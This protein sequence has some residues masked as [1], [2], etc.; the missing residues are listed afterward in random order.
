VVRKKGYWRAIQFDA[1]TPPS[2]QH[3][4]EKI[5]ALTYRLRRWSELRSHVRKG[6]DPISVGDFTA[7]L[8]LWEEI[9]KTWPDQREGY[10]GVI[11]CARETG[12]FRRATTVSAEARQRFP[13]DPYIA[14]ES[15]DF[16][17]ALSLWEKVLKARP[18]QPRG[19]R[20]VI[21]CA[22]DTGDFHRAVT[23]STEASQ[24]FPDD[25]YIIS[26]SAIT[27]AHQG[28]WEASV[29][30]WEK[31][32]EWPKA[33]PIWLQTYG[34]GLIV[35][36]RLDEVKSL[37]PHWH[38]RFP[39]YHGFLA[40]E[41]LLADAQ[42][43]WERAEIIWGELGKRFPNRLDGWFHYGQ[44]QHARHLERLDK[45]LDSEAHQPEPVAPAKIEVI[46]D[47]K[48]RALLL[49]FEN[50]GYNCEFG[51]VQRRFGAEPMGLLRFAGVDF[52]CLREAVAHRFD[53][54]GDP[55]VTELIRLANGEYFVRDRRWGLGMHT[56]MFQEIVDT[57]HVLPKL[58]RRMR[59]LRD[60]LLED[61]EEGRKIFVFS[62]SMVSQGDLQ[63]LHRELQCL[64][65]VSLLNARVATAPIDGQGVGLPRQAIEIDRRLFVGYLGRPGLNPKGFWDIPFDDWIAVCR[66][67]KSIA[68]AEPA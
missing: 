22:R 39:N 65:P 61:F 38:K 6:F 8:P 46:Q 35:L 1:I 42:E 55:E 59:F 14:S 13:D 30:S 44:S 58:C 20:G 60:K 66:S 18:D 52:Q 48:A 33:Q 31:V 53:R 34:H 28:N 54:M 32:V 23:V 27:F 25:P 15:G 24:R 47:E 12:D 62:S 43:D 7:A 41:G 10:R 19:Y 67:V 51:L 56:F 16:A 9:L 57:D 40:I 3:A 36:G 11:R 37:L 68:R 63:M 26:E 49:G 45:Y 4:L 50:V 17:A 5:G 29:A 64:G 21:Q 2:L